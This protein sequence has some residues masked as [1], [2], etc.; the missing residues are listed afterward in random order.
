[1][2]DPITWERKIKRP[3]LSEISRMTLGC[4]TGDD[5]EVVRAKYGWWF[6]R[7]DLV[8]NIFEK[9]DFAFDYLKE[10]IIA[11]MEHPG[12]GWIHL[13]FRIVHE[14]RETIL[15]KL[16]F[17]E[18]ADAFDQYG[19]E[20]EEFQGLLSKQYSQMEY[21]EA[22]YGLRK[23]PAEPTHENWGAFT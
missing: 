5:V 10:K 17:Y 14:T 6:D 11:K 2:N 13:L 4:Q 15:D 20:S 9:T 16:E 7:N 19:F 12:D 23:K 8:K 22:S 21:L 1:M 18:L 3:M